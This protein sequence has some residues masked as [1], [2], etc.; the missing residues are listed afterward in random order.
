MVQYIPP[1]FTGNNNL[2]LTSS[3]RVL[4]WPCSPLYPL[5]P[6]KRASEKRF[7]WITFFSFAGQ[8]F[9][10]AVD[11]K[12]TDDCFERCESKEEASQILRREEE[13]SK[14]FLFE[15]WNIIDVRKK[16]I[17]SSIDP[18][19]YFIGVYRL[20]TIPCYNLAVGYAAISIVA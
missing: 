17:S 9:S 19:I 14:N 1:C 3:G 2:L 10:R 8:E 16:D 6:S 4:L 15:F 18:F 12:W 20:L 13:F 5:P 7:R 11:D